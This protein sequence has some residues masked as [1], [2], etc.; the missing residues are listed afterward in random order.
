MSYLSSIF[1]D[2]PNKDTGVVNLTDDFFGELIYYKL[3]N[4]NINILVVT[5]TLY[6]ANTL[7]NIVT[8]LTDNVLLF[9]MEDFLTSEAVAISPDFL[10]TR[11]ETIKKLSDGNKYI[12][13]THYMG[14]SISQ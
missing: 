13:I 5:P 8:N 1:K 4:E 12:I 7:Y 6:E 14:N 2:I 9:P 3:V 11:L 10:A